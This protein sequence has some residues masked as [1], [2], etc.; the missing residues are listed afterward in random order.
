MVYEAQAADL[1]TKAPTPNASPSCF[2]SA[3][4]Y[5]R[6][7]P[8]ECP[9]TWNGT[10]LYGAIDTGAGYQTH[11]VPSN[12]AYPNGVEHLISKNSNA[13]GYNWMPNEL[14]S[15]TAS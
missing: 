4:D 13:P 1:P 5:F 12:G 11:G 6:A 15:T 3:A 2:D 9:L 10:T 14:V 8:Q 7:S